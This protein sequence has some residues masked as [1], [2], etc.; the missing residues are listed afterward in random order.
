VTDRADYGFYLLLYLQLISLEL[1]ELPCSPQV[2]VT[3]LVTPARIA[4]PQRVSEVG[5]GAAGEAA[6]EYTRNDGLG[7]PVS[8]VMATGIRSGT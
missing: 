7:V 3:F 5:R 2:L 6:V 8:T 1:L 4:G